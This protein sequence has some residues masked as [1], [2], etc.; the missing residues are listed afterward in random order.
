LALLPGTLTPSR[1][2]GVVRLGGWLPFGRAAE[3]LAHFTR[4]TV[5]E[6]TARRLTEG[7]GAAYDAVQAAAVARLERELPADP[8]GPP[9]QQLS[10]DGVLVP[11]LTGA[12]VAAK[13]RAI[14]TVTREGADG[15]GRATGLSSFARHA[16]AGEFAHQAL[17]GVHRRGTATAGT[18]AGIAGGAPWCPGVYAP[19]R[20]DAVRILD[21]DHAPTHPVAAAQAAFGAGTAAA[22]EWLGTQ[23]RAPTHKAPEEVLVAPAALPVEAAPSRAAA[24]AVPAEAVGYL[25]ARL[26]QARYAAFLAAGYP[27]GSGA[28]ESA[29]CPLG[30]VGG[31]GP[32]EA[33]REA[34]G[35]GARQP[36]AGAPDGGVQRSLGGGLAP[37]HRPSQVRQRAHRAT[38][39]RRT[40]RH[41]RLAPP[42]A[43]VLPP[44]RPDR[45]PH[46]AVLAVRDD[47]AR[48]P[49]RIVAGRPTEEHAW[50][51]GDRAR[52]PRTPSAPALPKP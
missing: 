40:E 27:I 8:A 43:P 51:R 32:A 39:A 23:C 3:L 31:R 17:G 12:R 38:T 41:A 47:L 45:P 36:D 30:D 49:P 5:G 2:E 52:C 33:G 26:E 35:A 1:Q 34:L 13:V 21:F 24:V 29:G 22:G 20:P 10:V 18:A 37:D 42:P 28:V 14:G 4:V 19:H 16:E 15:E 6:A 48:C 9:A 50:K 7:A 44:P 11:V 46:P 25:G